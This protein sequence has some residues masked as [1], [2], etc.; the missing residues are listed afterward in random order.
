MPNAFL[1]GY[2]QSVGLKNIPQHSLKMDLTAGRN[3]IRHLSHAH[4]HSKI[5]S[6]ATTVM[7]QTKQR[8]KV[9]KTANSEQLRV[10]EQQIKHNRQVLC[11]LLDS[12]LFRAKQNLPLRGHRESFGST[13][14][15]E[16]DHLSKSSERRQLSRTS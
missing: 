12:I 11:K 15:P 14:L 6:N 7:M 4:A 10:R 5:H 16:Y 1:A 8:L 2:L 13:R 3:Q 9:G